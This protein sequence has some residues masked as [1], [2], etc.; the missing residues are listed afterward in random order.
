MDFTKLKVEKDS[1]PNVFVFV[2]IPMDSKVKYEI[3]E[4]SGFLMADRFLFTSMKFPF[5]Y[6]F[7]PNT[8]GEDGDP[9]DVLLLAS[10]VVTPSAVVKARIIGMLEMK[11][12][13]GIDTK[14]I[15]VPIKK[16]DPLYGMYESI[17]DIPTAVKD[18]IKH[19]FDHYKELEPGKWVKTERFLSQEHAVEIV[20]KSL[21]K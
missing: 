21:Q 15:A 8:K 12:E 4:K 14:L 20:K 11:D 7:I 9:L 5:N 17:D 13:E 3:D 19:F 10:E 16:I 1:L 2:E 18:K 6:G